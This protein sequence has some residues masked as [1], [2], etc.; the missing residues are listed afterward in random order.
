MDRDTLTTAGEATRHWKSLEDQM[1]EAKT[2]RDEAIRTADTDGWTQ[3]DLVKETGLTR[4]TIRRIVN[5]EAAEAVKKAAAE[6]RRA[7]REES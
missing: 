3:T 1:K 7:K 6:K 5:P 4:E 2:E